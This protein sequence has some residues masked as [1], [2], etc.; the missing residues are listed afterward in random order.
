LLPVVRHVCMYSYNIMNSRDYFTKGKR[1]YSAYDVRVH[2][3]GCVVAGEGSLLQHERSKA[4]HGD[5]QQ[6]LSL[7]GAAPRPWSGK[8]G[9]RGQPRPCRSPQARSHGGLSCIRR[10]RGRLRGR[11]GRLRGRGSHPQGRDDHLLGRTGAPPAARPVAAPP[12]SMVAPPAS[13]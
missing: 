3:R 4:E 13:I 8:L 6:E 12:S 11:A 7:Q 2:G 9:G 1:P 5:R 10:L